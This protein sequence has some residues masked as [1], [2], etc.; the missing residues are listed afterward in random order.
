[1]VISRLNAKRKFFLLV[2]WI[3]AQRIFEC[4]FGIYGRNF[5]NT[6]CLNISSLFG[7]RNFIEVQRIIVWR[8]SL[9]VFTKICMNKWN[10]SAIFSTTQHIYYPCQSSVTLVCF[11]N[12]Q[13]TST[14]SSFTSHKNENK[15]LRTKFILMPLF[16][17]QT[18]HFIYFFPKSLIAKTIG[19]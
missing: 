10:M 18:N 1:M 12:R 17:P 15:M 8:L 5:A 3:I 19:D 11:P 9:F 4:F 2:T 14:I 7:E 16:L 13:Y 6:I